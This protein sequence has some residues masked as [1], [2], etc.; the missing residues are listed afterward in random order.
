[1]CEREAAARCGFCNEPLTAARGL[2]RSLILSARARAAAAGR[3]DADSLLRRGG[4]AAGPRK[5]QPAAAAF[6]PGGEGSASSGTASEPVGAGGGIAGH[7]GASTDLGSAIAHKDRLLE[8]DRNAA[9]RTHVFDDQADYYASSTSSWL[10]DEER[11]AARAAAAQ[12]QRELTTRPRHTRITLDF[13]GRSVAVRDEAAAEEADVRERLHA[14]A[15]APA[16]G[17]AAVAGS[18]GLGSAVRGPGPAA[19]GG[20]P[21]TAHGTSAVAPVHSGSGTYVNTTLRGRA[22]EVYA[23]ITQAAT[24]AASKPAP[25]RAGSGA[26]AAAAAPAIAAGG[27]ARAGAGRGR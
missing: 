21:S 15:L 5:L 23:A 14:L 7:G 16:G 8:F 25:A 11:A 3:L 1:V 27:S 13:A 2:N 24:A 18:A 12:R 20:R 19:A 9:K 4:A 17:G 6:V 26:V 10:S 22:A